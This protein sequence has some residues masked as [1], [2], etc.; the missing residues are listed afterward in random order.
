VPLLGGDGDPFADP[1]E[2]L[3]FFFFFSAG[4]GRFDPRYTTSSCPRSDFEFWAAHP[5]FNKP[6]RMS[7]TGRG[8]VVFADAPDPDNMMMC[9]ATA[10]LYPEAEFTL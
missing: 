6:R 3:F 9:L 7:T 5:S 4:M 1:V 10:Q 8:I 2:S